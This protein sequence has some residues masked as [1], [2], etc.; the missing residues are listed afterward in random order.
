MIRFVAAP[1]WHGRGHQ[2]RHRRRH[3]SSAITPARTT[4]GAFAPTRSPAPTSR[5]WRGVK[6]QNLTR[7]DRGS[8]YRR[9]VR[10]AGRDVRATT[11]RRGSTE[12]IGNIEA[13]ENKR[14]S[15]STRRVTMT[16]QASYDSDPT[17][18]ARGSRPPAGTSSRQDRGSSDGGRELQE[19][20]AGGSAR[21][22]A[23]LRAVDSHS[24]RFR[25]K[26]MSE[27]SAIMNFIGEYRPDLIP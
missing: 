27:A 19:L 3:L 12:A 8:R 26:D 11:R 22:P 24:V 2:R 25:A 1:P 6:R 23:A 21:V 5:A 18:R 16:P 17:A 4:R 20:P 13:A 15:G 10:R 14:S 7:G 9:A